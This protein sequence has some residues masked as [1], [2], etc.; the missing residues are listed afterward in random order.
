MEPK[1]I[2]SACRSNVTMTRVV[3]SRAT[4]D[5]SVE[6]RCYG[7]VVGKVKIARRFPWQQQT[8]DFSVESVGSLLR[9]RRW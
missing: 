5:F 9:K 6:G 2:L 7:N 4:F 1:I 8:F 3:C